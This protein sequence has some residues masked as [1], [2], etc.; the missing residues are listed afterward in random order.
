MKFTYTTLLLFIVTLSLS[1]QG[2]YETAHQ[3]LHELKH[4]CLLVRLHTS[5]TKI[6][7]LEQLGRPKEAKK[8][9]EK[10]YLENKE[11]LLSFSQIFDFCPVYFFYSDHSEAIRQGDF[12]QKLFDV[13]GQ[14]VDTSEIC[15]NFFTA[16]F[17]ETSRL[18]IDGFIIMDQQLFPLEAPF[19]YYQR[20]Y[21]LLGMVSLSKAKIIHRMNNRLWDLYKLWFPESA[22][23]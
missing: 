8:V 23:P 3:Q 12:H 16:E 2:K 5:D 14:T 22:T 11:I 6:Q 13:G 9:K 19:P 4:G 15:D 21:I 17:A 20:Q 1:A 18:G 7:A 10:Q